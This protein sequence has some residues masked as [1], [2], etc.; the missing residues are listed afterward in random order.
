[1]S[2]EDIIITHRLNISEKT[3]RRNFDRF[4]NQRTLPPKVSDVRAIH[5]RVDATYFGRWGCNIV[6]KTEN[7]IVF[8]EFVDRE[9]YVHYVYCF[10]RLRDLGYSVLSITSDK[11]KSII[12]AVKTVFPGVPHQYC[13]VHLQRSCQT[14]LTRNPESKA[15]RDL[16]HLIK[17]LNQIKTHTEKEVF[18]Y[19]FNKLEFEHKEFINHRS[20]GFKPNG[21]KT[22]WYTHHSVRRA[23]VQVRGSLDNIFLYLEDSSI[24]KDTNGLEV[25]FRHLKN[26]LD[27]HM[28]L[29]RNRRKKFILW[30]WYLKSM[31]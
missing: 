16:L 25:E 24:P 19:W 22:W 28:G 8:W 15:G 21:K 14:L 26:K 11:H 13:T 17:H 31:H 9:R 7:K 4:L 6:F 1:M 12:S 30:Y 20:F 2:I 3:L 18:T 5:L 10:S 27:A 29:K 23:Y